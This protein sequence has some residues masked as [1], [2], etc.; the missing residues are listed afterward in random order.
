MTHLIIG[1]LHEARK[2]E[3]RA[4]ATPATVSQLL[5]LGYGVA[6]ETGAGEAAS[7]ADRAYVEA[8]ANVGDS[9]LVGDRRHHIRGQRAVDGATGRVEAWCDAG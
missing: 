2:G 4:A 1:V 7:F 3:T 6:I 5:K 8:G 9:G